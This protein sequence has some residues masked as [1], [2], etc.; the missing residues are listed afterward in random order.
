MSIPMN[1][2]SKQ[3]SP[4]L[5]C[6]PVLLLLGGC[7]EAGPECGSLETRDSV[8]KTVADDRNN[9]LVSFALE[10][11]SS[12]A[13]MVSR[14]SNNPVTWSVNCGAKVGRRCRAG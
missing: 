8:L 11:S 10:N 12:V 5:F 13:A 7:G 2:F 3:P 9:R 1:P 6:L 4:A 14:Q